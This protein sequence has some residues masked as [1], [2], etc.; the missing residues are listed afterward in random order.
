MYSR[1]VKRQQALTQANEVIVPLLG[2]SRRALR[3][4]AS[5]IGRLYR[6]RVEAS[7][8]KR[9]HVIIID[10]P[11]S[12]PLILALYSS[13]QESRPTSPQQLLRR[14]GRLAREVAKLRGKLYE[15]ADIVY[16]YLSPRGFTSGAL[17][18]AKRQKVIAAQK[19]VEARRR[20]AKYLA[21]RYRKLLTTVATR[22]IWG[23]LPL[24]AYTL[25][26]LAHALQGSTTPTHLDLYAAIRG[27]YTGGELL[28][29]LE[30]HTRQAPT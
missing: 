2:A 5:S 6:V 23:E 19:P 9:V 26:Y 29:A 27:E 7:G 17:R 21:Q 16:V 28:T 4:A 14:I 12:H 25:A 15:Q 22:K 18:L 20:I 8:D 3:L 11:A 13:A 1:P 30:Q 10:L 24:L